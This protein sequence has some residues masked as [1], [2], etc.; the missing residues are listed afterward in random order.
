[1]FSFHHSPKKD[2]L[3]PSYCVI[4]SFWYPAEVPCHRSLNGFMK[5]NALL[6]SI[7]MTVWVALFS[8]CGCSWYAFLTFLYWK[9]ISTFSHITP[10]THLNMGW[11]FR[12]FENN[13]LRKQTALLRKRYHSMT[14][15]LPVTQSSLP[16][17]GFLPTEQQKTVKLIC[18]DL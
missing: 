15:A 16:H 4:S 5:T 1:M 14:I 7:F 10:I 2:G 17:C 9:F 12:L 3:Q 8:E 6:S 18:N 13:F 11:W